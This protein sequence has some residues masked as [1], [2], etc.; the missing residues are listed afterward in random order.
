MWLGRNNL[1]MLAMEADVMGT[2][3]RVLVLMSRDSLGGE[4]LLPAFVVHNRCTQHLL[5]RPAV[6]S[7]NITCMLLHCSLKHSSNLKP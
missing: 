2:D 1:C 7:C 5:S 4:T 6:R 3:P